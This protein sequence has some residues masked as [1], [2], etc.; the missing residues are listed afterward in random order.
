MHPRPCSPDFRQNAGH[1]FDP[2]VVEVFLEIMSPASEPL[3]SPT[4]T[5]VTRRAS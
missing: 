5:V 2:E 4:A 1:R 3:P